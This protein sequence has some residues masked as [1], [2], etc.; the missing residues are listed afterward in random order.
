MVVKTLA[1][2]MASMGFCFVLIGGG[3][4]DSKSVAIPI[5]VVLC[6]LAMMWNGIALEERVV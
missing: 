3:A 4:M 2:V 5:I 1:R 6:G